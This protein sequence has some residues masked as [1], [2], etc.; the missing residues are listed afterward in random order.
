M[1]DKISYEEAK[2]SLDELFLQVGNNIQQACLHYRVDSFINQQEDYI[3][4]LESALAKAGEW[5]ELS[6]NRIIH[7]LAEKDEAV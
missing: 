6:F 1:T 3:K 4:Y 7:L 5:N 2:Q